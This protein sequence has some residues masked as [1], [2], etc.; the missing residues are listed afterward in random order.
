MKK[1]HLKL[2][3][4]SFFLA[5]T[6]TA[7]PVFLPVYFNE[8]GLSNFQI[9]LASAI[10][11]IVA[12]I[13]SVFVGYLQEKIKNIKI[14]ISSYFGYALMPL[15]YLWAGSFLW[16]FLVKMYDGVISSLRYVGQYSALEQKSSYKT[17]IN[18]SINEAFS[19]IASVLGPLGAGALALYW[20]TD[21]IFI[22]SSIILFAISLY[23]L[24][25]I[26][27]R[28]EAKYA[29]AEMHPFLLKKITK[30]KQLFLLCLVFMLFSLVNFSKF[31]GV[32]LFMK[33]NGFND[34][35]IGLIGGSFFFFIF[36]FELFSGRL[37]K[38]KHR[39]KF[40]FLGFILTSISMF[41]FSTT[42]TNLYLLLF[43]ALLFSVGTAF[44]RPA[45][46][47]SLIVIENKHTRNG[48]GIL[49]FFSNLGG[50]LGLFISGIVTQNSF[51]Y[52]FIFSGILL[53]FTAF[54]S[55]FMGKGK[56]KIAQP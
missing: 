38:E 6:T 14:L 18:V 23:S 45:I 13:L 7:F 56:K 17:G 37:E 12:A 50:A 39:K 49:F 5:L 2:I 4:T 53:L 48:T 51:H 54:L 40:V 46:F 3:I 10:L 26:K 55:N 36:L 8:I 28:K 15:L 24:T 43:F 32:T 30:H 22:T 52:F 20:G 27:V 16:I 9:G 34:L 42:P 31:M 19:N 33:S 29:R 44:I 25:L 47:S 1:F 35:D 11:Y 21:S 41:L